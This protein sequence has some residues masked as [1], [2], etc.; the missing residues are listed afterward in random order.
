MFIN[1]VSNFNLVVG[2]ICGYLPYSHCHYLCF[3]PLVD[4]WRMA[5]FHLL[6]NM[7]LS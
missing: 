1:T 7:S 4:Y 5:T 6:M 2:I 3:R